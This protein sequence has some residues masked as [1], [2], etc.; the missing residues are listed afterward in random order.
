MAWHVVL[1][2]D[3]NLTYS[4]VLSYGFEFLQVR[5]VFGIICY[6]SISIPYNQSKR[7]NDIV[8]MITGSSDLMIVE[9]C[10]ERGVKD[11]R[12][13]V[14]CLLINTGKRN[15]IELLMIQ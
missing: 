7:R 14:K 1:G 2:F 10:D 3:D 4:L 9:I 11:M 5:E 6:E 15:V 12:S 13:Q 8:I